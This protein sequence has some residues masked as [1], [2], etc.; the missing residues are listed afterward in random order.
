MILTKRSIYMGIS[1]MT[2]KIYIVINYI[3]GFIPY[4][5]LVY[6]NF[7]ITLSLNSEIVKSE[8]IVLLNKR[9]IS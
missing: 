1:A 2:S 3:S 9:G 7:E 4:C 5:L 8:N 6:S